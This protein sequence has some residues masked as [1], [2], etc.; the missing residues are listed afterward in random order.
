MPA[1]HGFSTYQPRGAQ[2]GREKSMRSAC[3]VIGLN[4]PVTATDIDSV[5]HKRVHYIRPFSCLPKL[6]SNYLNYLLGERRKGLGGPEDLP[7]LGD[8]LGPF[9]WFHALCINQKNVKERGEQVAKMGRIYKECSRVIVYLGADLV[10]STP[11]R[12]PPRHQLHELEGSS[13]SPR[14]PDN[15]ELQQTSLN[16][17]ELLKRRYFSRIWAIQEL[18][19]AQSAIIRVGDLDLWANP[20]VWTHLA[21]VVP[22]SWRWDLT[23]A[24]WVQHMVQRNFPVK[25]IYKLMHLTS[26]CQAADPRD[27]LFGLLSLLPKDA[28]ERTW[29]PDYSLSGRHVFDGFF[30][31]TVSST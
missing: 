10:L 13:I 24:P 9:R 14:L 17:Q 15:C 23:A 28:Q 3:L 22:S 31:P 7:G 8:L 1:W 30:L 19:P 11:D 25:N 21:D 5:I 2:S 6:P 16:L 20:H 27:R 26:K 12:F 29:Q 4:Q 18:I